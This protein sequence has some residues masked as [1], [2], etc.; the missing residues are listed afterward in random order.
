VDELAFKRIDQPHQ[1]VTSHNFPLRSRISDVRRAVDASPIIF[2]LNC[3][4][5]CYRLT[6]VFGDREFDARDV[7]QCRAGRPPTR[8][9]LILCSVPIRLSPTPTIYRM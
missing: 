1:I 8:I 3:V 6:I 5:E 2:G 4:V 7:N 9:G